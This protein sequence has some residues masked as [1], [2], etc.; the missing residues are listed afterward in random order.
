MSIETHTTRDAFI[1]ESAPFTKDQR[2]WLNGFVAGLF[3]GLAQSVPNQ[4]PSA[5]AATVKASLAILYGSQTGT[6][7]QLAKKLAKEAGQRGY[8]PRLLEMSAFDKIDLKQEKRLLILTSTWGDGDPPDNALAFWNHLNSDQAPRL[9]HL[10]FSVLALGDRNYTNFCG[11]GKKFDARLEQLG[12]R[13]IHPCAECD[14]DYEA[15][16]QAWM[17]AMWPALSKVPGLELRRRRKSTGD[18]RAGF[19]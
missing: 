13:R 1:P 5:S 8:E 6:T 7:E 12:A 18:D 3:A 9:E 17:N 4:P 19:I 2:A 11:A 14:V 15:A 10:E 16:A